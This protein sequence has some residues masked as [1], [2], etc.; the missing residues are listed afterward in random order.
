MIYVKH[1]A[2]VQMVIKKDV[3]KTHNKNNK[4][5]LAFKDYIRKELSIKE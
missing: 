2:K 3:N 1:Y 4:K 5:I